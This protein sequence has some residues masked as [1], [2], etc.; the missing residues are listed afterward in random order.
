MV[1]KKVNEIELGYVLVDG[2]DI[3]IEHLRQGYAKLRGD[4]INCDHFDDY[5][6]AEVDAQMG[7]RG[8]WSEEN[9]PEGAHRFL[10]KGWDKKEFFEKFKNQKLRGIVE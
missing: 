7:E 5:K 2:R 9:K 3:L 4:K 6:D 10:K 8:V 1:E